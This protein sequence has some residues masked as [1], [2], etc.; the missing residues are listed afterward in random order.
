[1]KYSIC[2]AIAFVFSSCLTSLHP[3]VTPER[4]ISEDRV[5][6]DWV[7]DDGVIHISRFTKSEIYQ[8]LLKMGASLKKF[9]SEN[10]ALDRQDSIM[11]EHG[12]AVSYHKNGVDYFMFGAL[13]KVG[14]NFYFDL[15]PIIAADPKHEDGSGF[16]YTNDYLPAFTMAKLEISKNA[17]NLYF[18]NGDFIK[19]QIKSGNMRIKHEKDELFETFVVTA[20]SGELRQFVEKYGNDQRLYSKENSVTL[21]RK[22]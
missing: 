5:V 10:P 3:L 19:E 12:Y 22:G 11:Y 18:L 14:N 4:V 15:L 16:E 17:L 13:T 1:M 2:I 21:T 7:H 8:Q 6:G 9:G 20:S